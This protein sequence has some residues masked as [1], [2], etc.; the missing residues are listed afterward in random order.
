MDDR[1]AA[2]STVLAD[3]AVFANA[4]TGGDYTPEK[5]LAMGERI[6]SLSR[7]Y[8]LRTGRTHADDI[9]P[10]R[11]YEEESCS[12]LMKGKKISR[13]FFESQVQDY[14]KHRGWDEDGKPT[15][16]TLARLKLSEFQ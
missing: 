5:L 6:Q 2:E 10:D 13:E 14:F 15:E 12:G 16:E 8:N 1:V 3:R 9:L 4:A 7:L 11:F